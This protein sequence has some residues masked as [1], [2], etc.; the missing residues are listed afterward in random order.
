MKNPLGFFVELLKQPVWVSI[1][2]L[3]LMVINIASITFLAEPL[4]QLTFII[5]MM[6]AVIMMTL[7]SHFGFEKILGLGHILWI[8]LTLYIS[9]K[10]PVADVAFNYY[11]IALV[12]S[13]VISLFFDIVDVWKYF[14]LS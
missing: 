13:L 8:P 1:W 12:V 6:S 5:F 11:L 4:A 2:V 10:L 3:Y 7:Y 9:T 14:R